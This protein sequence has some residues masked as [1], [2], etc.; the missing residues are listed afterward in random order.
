MFFWSELFLSWAVVCLDLMSL[1]LFPDLE[2]DGKSFH[3]FQVQQFFSPARSTV[4]LTLR[5]FNFPFW[6]YSKFKEDQGMTEKNHVYWWF[7][8]FPWSLRFVNAGVHVC[9]HGMC[10]CWSLNCFQ[11]VLYGILRTTE[12]PRMILCEKEEK[13]SENF[14][15]CLS[16]GQR[17][18]FSWIPCSFLLFYRKKFTEFCMK[19]SF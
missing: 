15:T 18:D 6:N 1:F 10:N 19:T 13:N 5:E 8:F 17:P 11:T 16:L 9:E 7:V 4:A 14:G 2:A 3:R 12:A